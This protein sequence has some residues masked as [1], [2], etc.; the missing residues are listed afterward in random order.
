MCTAR[1]D[2]SKTLFSQK[3]LLNKNFFVFKTLCYGCG[4]NLR[5]ITMYMKFV[6]NDG[7]RFPIMKKEYVTSLNSE[8]NISPDIMRTYFYC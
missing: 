1:R 3:S 8:L 6:I 2:M 5:M 7:M 4:E